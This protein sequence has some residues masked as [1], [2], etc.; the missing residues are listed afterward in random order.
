MASGTVK[1]FNPQKGY[2]FIEPSDGGKALEQPLVAPRAAC[3]GADGSIYIASREGN[4]LRHV[5]LD[6]TIRTVVNTSGKKSYGG[7][8]GDGGDV[9]CVVEPQKV[10]PHPRLPFRFPNRTRT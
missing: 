1:W 2:G 3:Y 6:G 10:P 5:S 7:D 4:A 8:G 9:V